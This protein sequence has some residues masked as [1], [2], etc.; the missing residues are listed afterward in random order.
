MQGAQV[1]SCEPKFLVNPYCAT[2]NAQV[3]MRV[4]LLLE[5]TSYIFT[6]IYNINVYIQIEKI[7]L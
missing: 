2:K 5:D 1:G 4:Q 7:M 3:F 6:D